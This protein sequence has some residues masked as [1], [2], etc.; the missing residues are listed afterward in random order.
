MGH[1]DDARGMGLLQEEVEYRR[2]SRWP[3]RTI[4]AR[5]HQRARR[6]LDTA[7][8]VTLLHQGGSR[9]P[10]VAE[11][12]GW[13][14]AGRGAARASPTPPYASTAAGPRCERPLP[15]SAR[16]GAARPEPDSRRGL[17]GGAHL[18]GP[19]ARLEVGRRSRPRG[20]ADRGGPP[21]RGGREA[22]ERGVPR[23]RRRGRSVR[24]VAPRPRH[25]PP[26]RLGCHHRARGPGPGARLLPRD[27][28]LSRG[29]VE[30]D[31]QGVAL[32]LRREPHARR[33]GDARLRGRGARGR[34]RRAPFRLGR[35]GPGRRGGS[36][37][38]LE[39]RRPLVP[40][41]RVPGRRRPHAHAQPPH[42]EGTARLSLATAVLTDSV[43]ALALE[44]GF[45][46]VTAGPATPPEHG[47]ALRH[48]LEAGHAGTMGYLE[49]RVEERLDPA[50]V[51]PGARSVLCVALNYY[52]GEAPDPSWQP[53]ARYAWGRACLDACPTGAF[54]AP[55]V[56]DARRCVSY[57]TIEHR[58]DID[59]EAHAGMTGWQFGCDICQDVCPWNRKAPLTGE[60]AFEPPAPFPDAAALSGMDDE[61]LRRRF[62]GT[63]LLRAK[64][65]GLRRNATIYLENEA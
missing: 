8:A 23:G 7:L 26:L 60:A 58:G 27:G 61:S 17:R 6:P 18:A 20:A 40:L 43:K 41:H 46:L 47:P 19:R 55:Y 52:Q 15:R 14:L 59:S 49:R 33:A 54:V 36:R 10:S 63:P 57:L 38:P 28:V 11:R 35:G 45:D 22:H 3:L 39:G 32:R 44:L 48:W 34:S 24:A 31:R 29:P 13:A 25:R 1:A 5:C 42:R 53:V 9:A 56:L 12:P 21:A 64:P 65:S 51:L 62:A 4:P 30:G 16:R 50:R 2:Q 37:G